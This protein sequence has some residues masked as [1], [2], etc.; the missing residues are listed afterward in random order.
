MKIQQFMTRGFQQFGESFLIEFMMPNHGQL[1]WGIYEGE[2]M[3]T[4]IKPTN[5][6]KRVLK[7]MMEAIGPE[8]P[9]YDMSEKMSLEATL[10]DI[11]KTI[12]IKVI[13]DE[14]FGLFSAA[15]RA[16]MLLKT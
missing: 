2:I 6:Y 8:G 14:E 1:S 16:K 4:A 9:K 5:N 11:L 12:P 10:K 3:P 15:C 7:W 13:L